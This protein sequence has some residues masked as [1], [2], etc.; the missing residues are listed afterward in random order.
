M[1]IKTG[2]QRHALTHE[3]ANALQQFAFAVIDMLGDH[4]TVQIEVNGIDRHC[5]P[6]AVH[7][8]RGDSFVGV[9]GDMCGR[10]GRGG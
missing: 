7:D 1:Q 10:T 8:H 3:L 5:R 9:F 2:D 6:D 4:R